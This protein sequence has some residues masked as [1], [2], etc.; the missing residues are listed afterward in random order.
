MEDKNQTSQ[1][2]EKP[3]PAKKGNAVFIFIIILA[4]AVGAFLLNDALNK[5]KNPSAPNIPADEAKER[6]DILAKVSKLMLL[7]SGDEPVIA[8]I[9]DA[10]ALIAQEP[11]Y[12]GAQNGDKLLIYPQLR[13]AI[14]YSPERNI[15][16]NA[17]PVFYDNQATNG[18][19]S[20]TPP[21]A[22]TSATTTAQNVSPNKDIKVEI[23]N[24][25]K[26]KGASAKMAETL[27]KEGFTIGKTLNASRLTYTQTE[28]VNVSGKDVSALEKFFNLPATKTFPQGEDNK[29]DA[30]V[31]IILG[32]K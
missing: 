6:T 21:P 10:P 15:I 23:R 5:K 16:V 13:K 29:T 7:P 28:I 27:G 18:Q 22:E 12:G 30:D 25:T 11:F 26:V 32:L 8:T 24:G 14:I 19:V 3:M 9:K 20:T 1:S 4:L 2:A 31:V 17:G